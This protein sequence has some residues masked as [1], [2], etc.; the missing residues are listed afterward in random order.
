MLHTP[1]MEAVKCWSGNLGA[2]AT[3]AVVFAQLY[4]PDGKCH[5]LHPFVVAIR[6][7][8][9]HEVFPGLV[10]GD[11]MKKLGQNTLANGYSP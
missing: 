9:T 1:D 2:I 10:V 4:T 6:D 8:Q 3:H 7:Q 11:M 5:G